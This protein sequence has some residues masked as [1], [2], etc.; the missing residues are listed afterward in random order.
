MTGRPAGS[1]I[2]H[3]GEDQDSAQLRS[4]LFVDLAA[5]LSATRAA[6]VISDGLDHTDVERNRVVEVREEAARQLLG[7]LDCQSG[8]VE[9]SPEEECARSADT[10]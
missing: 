2:S 1:A 8:V 9:L 4:Q 10:R 7:L 6:A 3:I 5:C